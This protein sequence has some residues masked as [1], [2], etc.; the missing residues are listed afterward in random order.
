MKIH[1]L[2][3]TRF[4][5]ALAI[6]VFHKGQHIIPFDWSILA[7]VFKH[8]YIGVSYFFVLSGFILVVAYHQ[9]IEAVGWGGFIWARFARIYPIYFLALLLF[10]AVNI[11]DWDQGVAVQALLHATL[12]QAWVPGYPLTLNIPGWSLS[13]EAFFYLVFP[14]AL[15]WAK[16]GFFAF[17]M[18]VAV[19][20][21]I[22]Q[23]FTVTQGLVFDN[24]IFTPRH[25][26]LF[27]N[28]LMH[29]GTFLV[30]VV[31][32]LVFVRGGGKCLARWLVPLVA[33]IVG[34]FYLSAWYPQV[35]FHNGALA[36]V[37]ALFIIALAS[38]EGG[39]WQALFSRP[40]PVLLGEI[41]YGIYILQKPVHDLVYKP[42]LGL[43]GS[44]VASF[45][46]YILALIFISYVTYRLVECPAR[47][48]LSGYRSCRHERAVIG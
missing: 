47:R 12:L 13:A 4:L 26:F 8:S 42:L 24:E 5:A 43:T 33:V 21:L 46:L 39:R 18:L 35:K 45:Y 6:V 19:I 3:F 28:P 7:P 11:R 1:Q 48:L 20:W 38:C 31:A 44:T 2:T 16:R 9:R 30:G 29:L 22:T 40:L 14:I 32:G 17:A 37:F 27:Y 34:A 23:Y 15:L 41:S 36:P 10:L 25:D